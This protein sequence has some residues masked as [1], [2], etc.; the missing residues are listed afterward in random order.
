MYCVTS[1]VGEGTI[2]NLSAMGCSI[3]TDEPTEARGGL[4]LNRGEAER[5]EEPPPM[6]HPL[7]G[8]RRPRV[9]V[10]CPPHPHVEVS[11]KEVLRSLR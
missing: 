2:S 10:A 11:E 9:G 4:N 5:F 1:T 6:L 7:R 3:E 8:E